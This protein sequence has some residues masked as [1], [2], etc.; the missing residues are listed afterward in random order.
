MR[1]QRKEDTT[2]DQQSSGQQEQHSEEDEKSRFAPKLDF[3]RAMREEGSANAPHRRLWDQPR[4]AHSEAKGAQTSFMETSAPQLEE[5]EEVTHSTTITFLRAVGLLRS[6][7]HLNWATIS[8]Y[9]LALIGVVVA[10]VFLVNA[11]V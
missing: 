7:G 9:S 5:E 10:V 4:A 6:S 11:L 8:L 1:V 2:D 3:K